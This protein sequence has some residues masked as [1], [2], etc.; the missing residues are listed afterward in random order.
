MNV[1]FKF[2]FDWSQG[3]AKDDLPRGADS[4]DVT[5]CDG[6]DV[7]VI[8]NFNLHMF[9]T[10]GKIMKRWGD[11]VIGHR[12]CVVYGENS[13]FISDRDNHCVR[14]SNMDGEFTRSW[15]AEGAAQGNFQHISAI[16]SSNHMVLCLTSCE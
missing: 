9:Q 5:Y 10:N 1:I 12:T 2:E 4:S 8:S 16:E 13:L 14:V 15:G 7:I 3:I 11:G 6:Y